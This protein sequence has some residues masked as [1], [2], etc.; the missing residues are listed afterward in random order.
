MSVPTLADQGAIPGGS[1]ARQSWP[2]CGASL[3]PLLV[4]TV[5]LPSALVDVQVV[6]RHASLA[7]AELLRDRDLASRCLN[8]VLVQ[9]DD[10]SGRP[11]K[12][13]GRGVREHGGASETAKDH[14]PQ[15]MGESGASRPPRTKSRL[16]WG[17]S[18]APS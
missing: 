10:P 15:Q 6:E 14:L 13:C 5:M 8:I 18:L 17:R 11:G 2:R 3:R 16:R 1:F 4:V 7:I 9:A 12:D